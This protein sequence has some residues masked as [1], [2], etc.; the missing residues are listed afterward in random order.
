VFR[1]KDTRNRPSFRTQVVGRS[2]LAEGHMHRLFAS[3]ERDQMEDPRRRWGLS[4]TCHREPAN[5]SLS[6]AECFDITTLI[7]KNC[8]CSPLP[9][10]R[11][12]RLSQ[13]HNPQTRINPKQ[14]LPWGS[15]PGRT[16]RKD[17]Q[18]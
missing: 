7:P 1:Y 6:K 5:S 8:S 2:Q 13:C 4:G 10:D 12:Q 14:W 18:K 11:D 17:R 9:S 16:T 15:K 3:Q